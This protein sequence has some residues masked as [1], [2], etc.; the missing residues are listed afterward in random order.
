VAEARAGH[1]H[2]ITIKEDRMSLV[3]TTSFV[4]VAVVIS[5]VGVA[6]A[7]SSSAVTGSSNTGGDQQQTQNQGRCWDAAAKQ[8]RDNAGTVSGAATTGT[9]G[10]VQ[11]SKMTDSN[12]DPNAPKAGGTENLNSAGAGQSAKMGAS[13][14]ATTEGAAQNRPSEAQGLPDCQG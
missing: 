4:A 5:A 11:S 12:Q 8:V 9:P 13:D 2:P 3:R 14:S 1:A 7:A 10:A 6:K